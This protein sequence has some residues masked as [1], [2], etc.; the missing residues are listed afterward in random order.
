MLLIKKAIIEHCVLILIEQI[1]EESIFRTEV[2]GGCKV[3]L[4][5]LQFKYLPSVPKG[6]IT[7]AERHLQIKKKQVLGS[8]NTG[9]KSSYLLKDSGT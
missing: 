9:T 3:Y 7:L 4:K 5:I 1:R 2:T 8:I 6:F